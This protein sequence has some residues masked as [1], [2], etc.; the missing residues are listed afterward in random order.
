MIQI[1]FFASLRERL[2]VASLN[3]E[4]SGQRTVSDLLRELLEKSEQWSVLKEND[5][6][7]AVN[8][9]LCG[10]DARINDGDEIAFFPPVTGG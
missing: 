5:V 10:A 1:K 4:Y 2:G 6:L 3:F 9:T 8:Q 7:I